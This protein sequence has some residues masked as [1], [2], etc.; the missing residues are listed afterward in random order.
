M[1]KFLIS[2]EDM[3]TVGKKLIFKNK[4]AEGL[5]DSMLALFNRL[6]LDKIAEKLSDELL[7]TVQEALSA[8]IEAMPEV[9]I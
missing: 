9:E 1:E 8:A 6:V 5:D 7:P 4:L 3:K 2:K